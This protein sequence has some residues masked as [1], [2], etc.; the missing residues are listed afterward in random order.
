MRILYLFCS[1]EIMGSA[2]H[3]ANEELHGSGFLSSPVHSMSESTPTHTEYTEGTPSFTTSSPS[4]SSD[5]LGM[6]SHTSLAITSRNISDLSAGSN[7]VFIVTKKLTLDRKIASTS[8][9]MVAN[10][11]GNRQTRLKDLW[12][13]T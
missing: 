6:I 13:G 11:I 3:V 10:G 2:G 1:V 9:R 12:C 4:C 5:M 8:F 7:A